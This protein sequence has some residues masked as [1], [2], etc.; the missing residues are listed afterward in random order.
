MVV[1]M[2]MVLLGWFCRTCKSRFFFVSLCC[3]L[4]FF[5]VYGTSSTHPCHE[6]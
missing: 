6:S 2:G 4:L 5:F 1:L 3:S